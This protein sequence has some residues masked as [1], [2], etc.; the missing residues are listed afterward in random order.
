MK[1]LIGTLLTPTSL[2]LSLNTLVLGVSLPAVASAQPVASYSCQ[3]GGS[4]SNAEWV[5]VEGKLEQSDWTSPG[6]GR[7]ELNFGTIKA[8]F[9][10]NLEYTSLGD[11]NR[12][13][14]RIIDT[15][16]N[17]TV[18]SSVLGIDEKH[19]ATGIEANLVT[20][21][22]AGNPVFCQLLVSE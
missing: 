14:V 12:L 18:T 7:L 11:T 22:P 10:S 8:I 13:S 15:K 19:P 21:S 17:Y 16:N 3:L 6:N 1:T 2:F 9:K 4:N 5:T 20:G